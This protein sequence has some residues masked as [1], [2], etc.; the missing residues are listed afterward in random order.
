MDL[1]VAP[2]IE[3]ML[4]RS[5]TELPRAKG[6]L[7][8]PKWDDFRAILFRCRGDVY[9]SSCNGRPLQDRFRELV[10]AARDVLPEKCVVDGEGRRDT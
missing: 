1:A 4:A 2:P 10:A 6:W 8:E 9:I 7:Y 5:A 3:P